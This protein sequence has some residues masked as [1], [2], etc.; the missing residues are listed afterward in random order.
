MI[1]IVRNPRF[2]S[3]SRCLIFSPLSLNKTEKFF[4]HFRIDPVVGNFEVIYWLSS[5]LAWYQVSRAYV[6]PPNMEHLGGMFVAFRM[7]SCFVEV[8]LEFGD[9]PCQHRNTTISTRWKI[10]IWKHQG[11]RI[12]LRSGSRRTRGSPAKNGQPSL[13]CVSSIWSTTW[14]ATRSLVSDLRSVNKYNVEIFPLCRWRWVIRIR[15]LMMS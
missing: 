9:L 6:T 10:W 5:W 11:F 2:P 13:S 12:T 3:V 8:T 7:C 15:R 4:T 1:Y 14:T